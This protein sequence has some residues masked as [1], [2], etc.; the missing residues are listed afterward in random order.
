MNLE[1]TEQQVLWDELQYF[2]DLPQPDLPTTL[3]DVERGMISDALTLNNNNR[4]KTAQYLGIGRTLL[5]HKI[6]KYDL[7]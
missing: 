6:K 2:E 7:I 3:Q 1:K 4:T 5:I